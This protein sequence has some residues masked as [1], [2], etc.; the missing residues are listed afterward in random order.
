MLLKKELPLPPRGAFAKLDCAS[1]SQAD[2][3]F[4]A[5]RVF[6]WH[7]PVQFGRD[8]AERCWGWSRLTAGEAGAGMG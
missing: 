3:F 6:G 7:A 5:T 8:K 1:E 2:Q 4:E